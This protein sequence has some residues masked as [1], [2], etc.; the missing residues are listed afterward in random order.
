MNGLDEC[1][2]EQPSSFKPHHKLFWGVH[3]NKW[4]H[5]DDL[6]DIQPSAFNIRDNEDMSVDW[7]KHCPTPRDSFKFKQA[8]K[9]NGIME[10]TVEALLAKANLVDPPLGLEHSPYFDEKGT[11]INCAHSE[12]LNFPPKK[13][14][15]IFYEDRMVDIRAIL[16]DLIECKWAI[17]PTKSTDLCGD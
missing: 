8:P 3:C 12:I 14:L 2:K 16:T 5:W 6:D 15:S 4:C 7:S 17:K 13:E 9:K 11:L 10:I 1:P